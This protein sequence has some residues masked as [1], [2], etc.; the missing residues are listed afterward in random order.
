MICVVPDFVWQYPVIFG[1]R[2]LRKS[3]A[4]KIRKFPALAIASVWAAIVWLV[5]TATESDL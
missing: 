1:L 4:T 5:A 2:S 3:A